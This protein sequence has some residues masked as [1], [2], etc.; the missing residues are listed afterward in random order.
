MRVED[1][2]MFS[3][4]LKQRSG[5][6][7]TRDKAY[8]LES[9]LMPVARKW[10]MKGLEELASTVRTRKD[11]ALLRDI[12]EAM[13]TNESSF[14][15]DQKPFDQFKQI[16]LPKLLEA[17]AA[18]RSIRIWSAACSSGQ[19]AYSLA[20]LL[21]EDAAKLAGWRIE[22][23]GTDISAEMVERSKSGIYTQF[24]VQRGLPIQMLVRHFKQQGDKWQ[25]SQQLRQMASFRE[26]NLLGDLSTL[27]QFDIVF[28]R[29]V[30]IYF[31]QP[32]KTKVLEAI[33][34][35]MPQDG[36]LYLGGAETVLGI[37]DRFKPVEGQR[38]LYSLG[39]FQVPSGLRAAV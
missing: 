5:L 7:L 2:D 3:T 34:R 27:G 23:V 6:V 37:T 4:L 22:I 19:E 17:R 11:E 21:S 24:E 20:M 1:F 13:T 35:Q 16:V 10:N 18:K 38:G 8:L 33:A 15:R 12:T 26:F 9:R 30:L 25:I 36:V 14:F 29:N 39:G 28:C 32:T 31:D